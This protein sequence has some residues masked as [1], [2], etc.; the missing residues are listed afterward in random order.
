MERYC[1][2]TIK[3]P[4]SNKV[5]YNTETFVKLPKS[6]DA[7]SKIRLVVESQLGEEIINEIEL[8]TNGVS[9]EKL[10]GE[11]IKIE[12]QFVTPRELKSELSNLVYGN[13]SYINIPFW[14]LR[15]HFFNYET[16]RILFGGG[17][18]GVD[19][20]TGYLLVDY[21]VVENPPKESESY[22]HNVR[23]VS[24]LTVPSVNSAKKLNVDTYIP[25]S[26][27]E[28]WVTIKDTST[29][30]YVSDQ[31]LERLTLLIGNDQ[32]FSISGTQ[33]R[34]TEPLKIYGS[35]VNDFPV[36]MYSFH[37][38]NSPGLPSGQTN[39]TDSQR[40][41]FDFVNNASSYNVTLW[42]QYHDFY[43][44]NGTKGVKSMFDSGELILA[45]SSF[46]CTA[47]GDIQNFKTSY[48]FY[49]GTAAVQYSSDVEINS[50]TITDTSCPSS[51][52]TQNEII[53]S[54]LDSLNGTYYANV[55]FHSVGYKDVT[56]QYNFKS[57]KSLFYNFNGPSIGFFDTF[58]SGSPTFFVDGDQRI[59]AYTGSYLNGVN[60]TKTITN[61]VVDQYRNYIVTFSDGTCSK[62]GVTQVTGIPSTYFDNYIIPCANLFYINSTI[63][64]VSN[65]TLQSSAC[66]SDGSFYVS[67]TTLNSNPIAIDG[68][69][70][71]STGTGIKSILLKYGSY[72]VIADN[73]TGPGLVAYT[74]NGPVFAFPVTSSTSLYCVGSTL[75]YST[76]GISVAQLST[77]GAL[78]WRYTINGSGLTLLKC[79]SDYFDCVLFSYKDSTN[80]YVIKLAPDGTLKWS[81]SFTLLQ[82]N[83]FTTVQDCTVVSY[84]AS[85][86]SNQL[87]ISN[88]LIQDSAKGITTRNI[89]VPAG[90]TGVDVLD[91]NGTLVTF[92][93]TPTSNV[94]DFTNKNK[95]TYYTPLYSG[96]YFSNA[97]D[98]NYT[99]S[100]KN[101]WGVFVNG[102][103]STSG[104]SVD[105]NST[106]VVFTG[107]YGPMSTN[108][109]PSTSV[110][111]PAT[112]K[113]GTFVTKI[114]S[115]TGT[116]K[117]V[118][119]ID[120]TV[121]QNYEYSVNITTYGNVYASGTYG[122]YRA[123]VYNSDGTVFNGYLPNLGQKGVYLVKYDTNG[124]AL[125][126]T[127]I[128]GVNG[129][130]R[131]YGI[132]R[133]SSNTYIIG[134]KDYSTGSVSI[135]NAKLTGDRVPTLSA[136]SST[137]TTFIVNYDLNG[138]AQWV[139]SIG[140]NVV[141][142]PQPLHINTD[143]TGNVLCSVNYFNGGFSDLI[144]SDG[145]SFGTFSNLCA[146][147]MTSTGFGILG[148]RVN[149]AAG[150]I[151]AS[152]I[153]P[154]QS[155]I[156]VTGQIGPNKAIIF[157]DNWDN[158]TKNFVY[159][160]KTINP[161]RANNDC[162]G[163]FIAR[164]RADGIFEWGSY[165]IQLGGTKGSNYPQSIACDSTGNVYVSGYYNNF[166]NE[167]VAYNSDG[168]QFTGG[169]LPGIG[170][171][172]EGFWG[173]YLVKYDNYGFC[174]WLVKFSV[175]GITT[176]SS[177]VTVTPDDYIILSGNSFSQNS[178][179][180]DSNG[181]EHNCYQPDSTSQI[182]SYCVK[183]DTN[184]FLVSV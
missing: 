31:V 34:Y 78:S 140:S 168:T 44:K 167:S 127:Y 144:Q 15:K 77:S 184:G 90:L 32:R 157:F 26:I 17:G 24:R 141:L 48:T 11:F 142:S 117:W 76:S 58:Y 50:V 119:Y 6:G 129:Q 111:L 47:F 161:S 164:Y 70:V 7:I 40:F 146:I 54:G 176:F 75:T 128:D 162:A 172:G 49:A 14:C 73:N 122:Q 55:V 46:P 154:L 88:T 105:R 52:V 99:K 68:T 21:V 41:V 53:F 169:T 29:D 138:Q 13:P 51:V 79:T 33:M 156:Y 93:D 116:P 85:S 16:L 45:T 65:C 39:L 130:D 74:K 91:S 151:S 109:F 153:S 110:Y 108:V 178:K 137:K 22:F 113:I 177:S 38:K 143:T 134:W 3:V 160:G 136:F 43:Y 19:E 57:P 97:L 63:H 82:N 25:G 126:Q 71:I 5:F 133:Y 182:F 102:L 37:L 170:Y 36:Y 80:F 103:P 72:S 94:T 152:A 9:I 150:R 114:D 64:T 120:N 60:Y 123:N 10:Y 2:Q 173:G 175:N 132:A 84:T 174:K 87:M 100:Y 98:Y 107:Q 62:N 104:L 18:G 92:Y 27:Y 59:N 147:K 67:G 42:A 28:I 148:V 155:N 135:Y 4:F 8:I 83:D 35:Y 20:I 69:S 124:N 96:S 115:A 171:G 1:S 125:W 165:I 101:Y 66:S 139:C 163:G 56:C 61:V 12:N 181:G 183:Y 86:G 121:N 149:S 30:T 159:S 95:Q 23:N 166:L 145:T 131:A 112:D 179:F 158:T 106:D 118:S 89:N 81:R 180:Y